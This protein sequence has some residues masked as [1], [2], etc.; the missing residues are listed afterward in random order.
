MEVRYTLIALAVIAVAA[1]TADACHRC[2]RSWC[3]GCK[4]VSSNKG[5]LLPYG[6]NRAKAAA[7]G[8]KTLAEQGNTEVYKSTPLTADDIKQMVRELIATTK[9]FTDGG[10][11]NFSR[12]AESNLRA[13]N[14]VNNLTKGFMTEGQ[15]NALTNLIVNMQTQEETT[16]TTTT[17]KTERAE[18]GTTDF[19]DDVVDPPRFNSLQ[20]GT[21]PFQQV[22]K[23]ECASCHTGGKAS[24]GVSL[25]DV[26]SFDEK[27]W[28]RIRKAMDPATTVRHMP[29][30]KTLPFEQRD[31]AR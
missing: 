4:P 10:D 11:R 19:P 16:T 28:A 26:A 3:H 27:Q 31:R 29:P 2:G 21:H 24:G 1:S 7:N 14:V 18:S 15:I 8:T 9:L 12:G 20:R 6:T 22:V 30:K 17:E 25:D 13:S 5:K 23:A